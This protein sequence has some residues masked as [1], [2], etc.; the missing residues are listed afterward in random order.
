M[1]K[2][3]LRLSVGPGSAAYNRTP[4]REMTR[5]T[6]R[7]I[8]TGWHR[9]WRTRPA[10]AFVWR[11]GRQFGGPDA[12]NA[13]LARA[14]LRWVVQWAAR[15]GMRHAWLVRRV[16]G[17]RFVLGLIDCCTGWRCRNRLECCPGL[18]SRGILLLTVYSCG[19]YCLLMGNKDV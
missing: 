13:G 11:K 4:K 9:S 19:M 3:S 7:C 16:I 12:I 18:S 5:S 2:G 1:F 17:R 14:A 15:S 8:N 10:A 6:T